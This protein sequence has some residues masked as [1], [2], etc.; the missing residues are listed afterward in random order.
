M[1]PHISEGVSS[2][3]HAL[4]YKESNKCKALTACSCLL[5]SSLQ[6]YKY[7]VHSRPTFDFLH[8]C[9]TAAAPLLQPQEIVCSIDA[10]ATLY[11]VQ[12]QRGDFLQSTVYHVL[13]GFRTGLS[14][15]VT[16]E[17]RVCGYAGGSVR[18][19]MS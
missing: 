14:A 10:V 19:Y 18:L 5:L 17:K 15:V 16:V 3:L 1:S 12:M 11:A 9:R 13:R 7:G 8:A 2:V 6:M 4:L